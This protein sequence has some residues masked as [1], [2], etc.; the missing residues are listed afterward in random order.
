MLPY[1]RGDV[2]ELLGIRFGA[3]MEPEIQSFNPWHDV[4]VQ[5]GDA[6][7]SRDAVQLH[8]HYAGAGE[9]AFHRHRDPL[10]RAHQRRRGMV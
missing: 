5:V 7:T 6:L 4:H 8:E 3:P 10:G 2:F 1:P 9:G